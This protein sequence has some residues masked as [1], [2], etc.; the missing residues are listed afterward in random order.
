MSGR[1]LFRRVLVALDCSPSSLAALE[2]AANVAAAVDA[3][4][5]G[6]F[7]EDVELLHSAEHP[8]ARQVT[9]F[10]GA[11]QPLDADQMRLQLRTLAARARAAL[12][13]AGRRSGVRCSFQVRQGTVAAVLLE[14]ISEADVVSLGRVGWSAVG[15]DRLGTTARRLLAS[16]PASAL[17]ARR[18]RVLG[19]SIWA[20]FDGS[21]QARRA[22]AAAAG[23]CGDRSLDVVVI[24]PD[25]AARERLASGV[26]AD[27]EPKARPPRLHDSSTADPSEALAALRGETIG[28]LVL[29][30]NVAEQAGNDLPALLADVDC[31]VLIVRDTAP[32]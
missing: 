22:L 15:K 31:P 12:A 14:E 32:P 29:P 1:A 2:A 16:A 7:V 18:G 21:P 3:E 4:L 26:K 13:D 17:L 11:L 23:L 28:L 10:S 19:S 9:S 5:L 8:M 30:A 6:L 25:E 27:L 24:G 20:L